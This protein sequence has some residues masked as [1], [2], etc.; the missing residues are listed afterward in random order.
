M[1]YGM[2]MCFVSFHLFSQDIP[3]DELISV[4]SLPAK[5][6]DSLLK[7][8]HFIHTRSVKDTVFYEYISVDSAKNTKKYSIFKINTVWHYKG[9]F[10]YPR[11]FVKKLVLSDIDEFEDRTYWNFFY[12]E[13]FLSLKY[14][15]LDNSFLLRIV[16]I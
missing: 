12:K 10:I 2:F 4:C 9:D 6:A 1:L 16:K 11:S 14:N 7:M 13:H 8:H 3:I 5:R 15:K